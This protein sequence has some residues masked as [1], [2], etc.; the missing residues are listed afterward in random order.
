MNDGWNSDGESQTDY[1]PI[2]SKTFARGGNRRGTATGR[3]Y[4]NQHGGRNDCTN[5]YKFAVKDNGQGFQGGRFDHN[6]R[7]NR[8]GGNWRENTSGGQNDC[9]ERGGNMAEVVI[10]ACD[11]GKIIGKGGT[12]IRELQA[13]SRARIKVC[14]Y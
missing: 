1:A 3:N 13:E 14:N 7:Q 11:V 12:K 2:Y 4:G 8:D 9:G 6:R 10:K 5:N